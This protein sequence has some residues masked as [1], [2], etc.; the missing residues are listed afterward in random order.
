MVRTKILAVALLVGCSA[1]LGETSLVPEE[2]LVAY[3]SCV[4]GHAKGLAG[5]PDLTEN[6]VRSALR[7]CDSKRRALSDA[8]VRAGVSSGEL[9]A[10]LSTFEKRISHAASLAILEERDAH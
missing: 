4:V 3:E 1:G 9:A 10:F 2:T 8:L 6:I 5:S 7:S